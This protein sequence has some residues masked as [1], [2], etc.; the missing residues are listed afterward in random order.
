MQKALLQPLFCCDDMMP[1]ARK[2]AASA[3]H[4]IQGWLHMQSFFQRPTGCNVIMFDPILLP[5]AT[6]V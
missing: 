4:H 3:Q 5:A 6:A 2:G 1:D